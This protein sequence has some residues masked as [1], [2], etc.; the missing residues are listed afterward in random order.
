MKFLLVFFISI[1]SSAD[2]VIMKMTPMAPDEKGC[3][4]W[5]WEYVPVSETNCKPIKLPTNPIARL[6]PD[7][8]PNDCIFRNIAGRTINLC[9]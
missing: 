6:N 3:V 9:K 4:G 5:K 2:C 8:D 7:I 1:S